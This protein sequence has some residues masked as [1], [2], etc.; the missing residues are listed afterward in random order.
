M[1]ERSSDLKST[2]EISPSTVMTNIPKPKLL[3]GSIIAANAFIL[4]A[5][6][7]LKTPIVDV[8]DK[9]IAIESKSGINT[10]LYP[11]ISLRYEKGKVFDNETAKY[12]DKR[13]GKLS[14]GVTETTADI[15][16]QQIIGDLRR[17]NAVLK[18]RL[19]NSLPVHT[20]IYMIASSIIGAV[21][22]TLLIVRYFLNVYFWD[23]YYLICTIIISI[24]LF[25]TALVS[26]KDWKNFLNE[27]WK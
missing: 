20:L 9:K 17:E 23:P 24:T 18:N 3:V 19:G 7:I 13:I 15:T 25:M 26:L 6:P 16:F 11:T 14:V 27:R 8:F 12:T 1:L 5:S 21:S 10:V 22:T 2:I 4:S